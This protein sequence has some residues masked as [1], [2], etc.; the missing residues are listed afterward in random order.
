[1]PLVEV[2]CAGLNFAELAEYGSELRFGGTV[3]GKKID[4]TE[5]MVYLRCASYEERSAQNWSAHISTQTLG[6]TQ[7]YVPLM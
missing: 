6:V 3:A 2:W 7:R 5:D 4:S 1:M